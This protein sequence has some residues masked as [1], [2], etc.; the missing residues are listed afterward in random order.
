MD[1]QVL[2]F[3][4]LTVPRAVVGGRVVTLRCDR[5]LIGHALEERW[6]GSE[7]WVVEP[8]EPGRDAAEGYRNRSRLTV[9]RASGG[10]LLAFP[11][12]SVEEKRGSGTWLTVRLARRSGIE[13]RFFPLDGSELEDEGAPALI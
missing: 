8:A 3:I 9:V 10:V 7:R 4:R 5:E 13:I 6:R 11:K 12:T 2:P 1:P